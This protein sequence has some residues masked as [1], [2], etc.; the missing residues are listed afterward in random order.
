MGIE[1]RTAR[2]S[3]HL[4]CVLLFGFFALPELA[5]QPAIAG[6]PEVSGKRPARCHACKQLDAMIYSA[7]GGCLIGPG[8]CHLWM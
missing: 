3:R 8:D 2:W 5:P 7:D 4:A 6:A 1:Q